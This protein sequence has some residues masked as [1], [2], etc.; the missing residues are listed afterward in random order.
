MTL[1]AEGLGLTRMC[2]RHTKCRWTCTV[3]LFCLC[4]LLE[5]CGIYGPRALFHRHARIRKLQLQM[6]GKSTVED[7]SDSD[8]LPSLDPGQVQVFSFWLLVFRQLFQRPILPGPC[9]M[10]HYTGP[11]PFMASNARFNVAAQLVEAEQTIGRCLFLATT[12]NSRTGLADPTLCS[13]STFTLPGVRYCGMTLG[14]PCSAGLRR[15]IRI[16]IM[17]RS[18]M[19]GLFV[20]RGA[21][22][23]GCLTS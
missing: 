19:I 18:W 13:D 8:D 14:S 7:G 2:L 15:T 4:V 16:T 3:K 5:P 11:G 9:L 23:D 17:Y 12:P 1:H 6:G 20:Y 10:T 21:E 22:S